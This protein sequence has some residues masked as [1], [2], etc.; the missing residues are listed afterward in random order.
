MQ[1]QGKKIMPERV[2]RI[3]KDRSGTVVWLEEGTDQAGLAHLMD[4]DRVTDF[5]SKGVA[6]VDIVDLVFTALAT[7]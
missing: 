6:K 5:A 3:G 1:R 4:P 7:G 2:V